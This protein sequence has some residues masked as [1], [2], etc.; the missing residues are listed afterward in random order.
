MPTSQWKGFDPFTPLRLEEPDWNT[1]RTYADVLKHLDD[2]WLEV[3]NC[4]RSYGSVLSCS[5]GAEFGRPFGCGK[6]SCLN[7]DGIQAAKR[8]S[9][10]LARTER[11]CQGEV[12]VWGRCVFTVHP[13]HYPYCS[14]KEGSV[15]MMKRA[16]EAIGKVLGV[17][18]K[19]L[20]SFTTFHPTSSK[21]P[22]KLH[23][24][25]ELI[26]AHA[27][28]SSDRID[29]LETHESGILK[30]IELDNLQETWQ[31]YYPG[32]KNLNVSYK[33]ELHFGHMRYLVRPMAEDVWYAIQKGVLGVTETGTVPPTAE[34]GLTTQGGVIFWP[35]YHRVRWHGAAS[36]NTFGSLMESLDK[37]PIESPK[38]CINCP[39]CEDGILTIEREEEGIRTVSVSPYAYDLYN[40][41]F[42]TWKSN[43]RKGEEAVV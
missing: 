34:V 12:F 3:I 6:R 15:R 37:P 23:P 25:V 41:M 17:S 40:I 36:N 43:S 2:A 29:P 16:V 14:S 19:Q 27:S 20:F 1:S 21:H 24:H 33:K 13:D 42:T 30:P 11:L 10:I 18:K 28:V 26:W 9:R 5:C 38:T 7:C 39:D 4:G 22:W 8:A 32:T 31:N 35:S